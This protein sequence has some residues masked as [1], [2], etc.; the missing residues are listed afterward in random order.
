MMHGKCLHDGQALSRFMKTKV[1]LDQ[2]CRTPRLGDA[3]TRPV[4]RVAIEYLGNASEPPFAY[5]SV[6]KVAD[7]IQQISLRFIGILGYPQAGL[8]IMG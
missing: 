5:M 8:P 3:T 6:H 1:Q 4:G 7:E 2:P